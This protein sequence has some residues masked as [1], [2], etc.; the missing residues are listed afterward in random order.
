MSEAPPPGSS[1]GA[2]PA[3]ALDDRFARI[4]RSL[5]EREHAHAAEI[6]RARAFAEALRAGVAAA[7]ADFESAAKAE[8]RG[9]WGACAE[10]PCD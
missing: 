4:G 2:P 6:E 8:G 3:F 5:G 1:D 9:M 10:V 7:L